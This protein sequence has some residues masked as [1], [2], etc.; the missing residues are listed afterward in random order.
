MRTIALLLAAAVFG[1]FVSGCTGSVSVND[2]QKNAADQ[3]KWLKEHPGR[4]DGHT[5]L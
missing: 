5:Q 1:L 2:V 3:Q 4:S